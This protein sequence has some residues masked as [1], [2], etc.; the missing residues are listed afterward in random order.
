MTLTSFITHRLYPS[1][2]TKYQIVCG[3]QTRL[4]KRRWEKIS[5]NAEWRIVSYP[6]IHNRAAVRHGCSGTCNLPFPI[7]CSLAGVV[8]WVS[9]KRSLSCPIGLLLK[10]VHCALCTVQWTYGCSRVNMLMFKLL[11]FLNNFKHWN[12][13]YSK[14]NLA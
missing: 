13:C 9:L 6:S 14:V 4:L 1:G 5:L 7:S 12:V 10:P 3:P 11:L 8:T 2:L